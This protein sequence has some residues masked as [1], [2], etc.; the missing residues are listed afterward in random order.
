MTEEISGE[1][2]D[3]RDVERL[4]TD[5][6]YARCW[7]RS[8][9]DTDDKNKP[10]TKCDEAFRFRNSIGLNG[11]TLYIVVT[12]TCLKFNMFIVTMVTGGHTIKRIQIM[13]M[14]NNIINY[15]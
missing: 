1:V 11:E 12:F 5:D 10:L 4:R 8:F 15:K 14:T 2:Y 13:M 9:G 7:V 6:D 3:A